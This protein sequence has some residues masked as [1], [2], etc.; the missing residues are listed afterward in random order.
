MRKDSLRAQV[1]A[2]R[3]ELVPGRDRAADAEALAIDALAAAHDAGVRPGD[4]VA[5]YESLPS[6]PPTEAAIAALAARGIRVIVPITQP[7]WD[8]D[9]REAGTDL[10]LGTDAVGDA[11]LV[12]VPAQCVDAS[13]TRLGRGRGC[14]DRVLPRTRGAVVAVVHPWEVT[15]EVLPAEPHDRPVDAVM[16]A[17]LGVRWFRTSTR[18]ART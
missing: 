4:W 14:Y 11:R 1:G 6:E 15:D 12:L 13:G 5:A 8:L 16:A 17:G 2:R 7:D 18:P 9:W 3:R 10:A